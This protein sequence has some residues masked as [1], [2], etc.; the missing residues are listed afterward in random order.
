MVVAAGSTSWP[1]TRPR[2]RVPS[3][4]DSPPLEVKCA[5]MLWSPAGRAAVV[6][7][8][9]PLPSRV[10][11][12]PRS[13]PSAWNWTLPAGVPPSLRVTLAV[14]VVAWP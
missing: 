9:W 10:C 7:A 12:A 13:V 3:L 14:N 8:A 6:M 5:V 2:K 1:G 11:G 4:S